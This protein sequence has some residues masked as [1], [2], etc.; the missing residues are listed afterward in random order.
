MNL[1]PS[2]QLAYSTVRI[3]CVISGGISTGTGFFFRFAETAETH[4]PAIVTNKHVIAGAGAGVIHM[5]AIDESGMPKRA[6]YTSV[7]LEDFATGWIHHPDPSIDLAA[8]P[9]ASLIQRMTGDARA[10]F[11]IALTKSLIPIQSDM[12]QFTAVED[13]LM[14]GYPNG[15]WDSFNNMPIFRRG[16]TATHPRLDY[17]G[18]S[19]F[20]IDA[21]CFPGSSGS[22]VVLFN[23][24][25]YR[26]RTGGIV[27]GTR[28]K[29]LGVLYAGHEHA[30][31]GDISNLAVSDKQ[32]ALSFI[33][34]NLGV[35]IKAE[36]LGALDEEI[37]KRL[38]TG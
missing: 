20:I 29:L 27:M 17:C 7:V 22:P 38:P 21:A 3:E 28:L 11:F 24:G 19:E 13:I 10:P 37:R 33:P 31:E 34:N 9:V 12:E 2:E 23:E 35:V 32:V 16:I 6:N 26:D 18:R 25:T 1:T 8:L 30:V 5:H 4:I 14:I 36:C 15:I